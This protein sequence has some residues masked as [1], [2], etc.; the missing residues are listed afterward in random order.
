MSCPLPVDY[1]TLTLFDEATDEAE[2]R[3][4]VRVQVLDS[5]KTKTQ[6]TS[7]ALHSSS[8]ISEQEIHVCENKWQGDKN[9]K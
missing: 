1:S 5:D 4:G 9:R 3:S 6:S 2:D 7:V 8:F